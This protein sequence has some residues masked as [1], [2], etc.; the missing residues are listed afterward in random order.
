MEKQIGCEIGKLIL[1]NFQRRRLFYT[2]NHPN[3]QIIGM[4]MQY[5]LQ[6]LGMDQGYRPNSTL[7]HLRRV[8]VPVPPKGAQT[9]G[10]TWAKENAK[11]LH[12]G[13]PNTWGNCLRP[14]CTHHG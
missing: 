4:L 8:Q 6:K 14:Y 13:A 1:D 5:L 10:I 2:T 9:L 7:D 12:A 11:Y 3:G